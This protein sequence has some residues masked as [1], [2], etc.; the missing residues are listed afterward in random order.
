MFC[1]STVQPT[2][3][4]NTYLDICSHIKSLPLKKYLVILT[5]RSVQKIGGLSP[6]DYK[7]KFEHLSKKSQ[8]MVLQKTVD[9]QGCEVK[10]KSLLQRHSLPLAVTVVGPI[11]P[12]L[13]PATTQQADSGT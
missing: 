5:Q 3:I 6:I 8:E 7:F 2:D 12:V 9:F 11:S 13:K 1:D 4:S 10:M